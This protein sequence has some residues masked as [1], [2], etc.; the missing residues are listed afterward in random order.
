MTFIQ[1]LSNVFDVEPTLHKG[2]TNVLCLL[3]TAQREHV[4]HLFEVL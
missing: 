2:F 4:C 1:R 3:G